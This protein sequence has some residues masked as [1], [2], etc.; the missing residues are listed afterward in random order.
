MA[1]AVGADSSTEPRVAWGTRTY[2]SHTLH[3]ESPWIAIGA[4]IISALTAA[5][6]IWKSAQDRRDARPHLVVNVLPWYSATADGHGLELERVEAIALNTSTS[7]TTITRVGVELVNLEAPL[8]WIDYRT[9]V[10][11]KSSLNFRLPGEWVR[12]VIIDD[13]NPPDQTSCRVSIDGFDHRGRAATW[14]SSGITIE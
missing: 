5:H 2:R 8:R 3:M 11:P 10:G 6:A 9:T 14:Y 13:E 1:V 4:L 12:D 7:P